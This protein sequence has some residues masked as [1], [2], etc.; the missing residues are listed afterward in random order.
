M[1]TYT[2]AEAI[3][4]VELTKIPVGDSEKNIIAQNILVNAMDYGWQS[5]GCR[6]LRE[7]RFEPYLVP[8]TFQTLYYSNMENMVSSM[9]CLSYEDLLKIF[10]Y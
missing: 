4:K 5:G 9:R 1:E 10:I 2:R 6:I 7:H 3:G 8:S